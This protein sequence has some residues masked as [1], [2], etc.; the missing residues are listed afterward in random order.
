MKA[1]D[2]ARKQLNL[3]V[4]LDVSGSMGSPFDSYYYDQTVQPTAGVPDE[5]AGRRQPLPPIVRAAFAARRQSAAAAAPAAAVC[6]SPV[7]S[8]VY[9]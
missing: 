8:S 4:V 7:S 2:F 1:A 6:E 3:V 9:C 5:G